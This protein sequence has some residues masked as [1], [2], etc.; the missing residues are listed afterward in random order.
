MITLK[1]FHIHL[2]SQGSTL[3]PIPALKQAGLLKVDYNEAMTARDVVTVLIACTAL[4]ESEA[5]EHVIRTVNLL[6]ADGCS[7]GETLQG[8]LGSGEPG[9]AA[10]HVCHSTPWAR[11]VFL[12]GNVLD[13]SHENS[14]PCA[15]RNEAVISG[16]LVSMLSMKLNQ[17]TKGGWKNE[18]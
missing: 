12:N 18:S 9:I 16:G 13:Y 4:S 2:T 15:I 14:K 17:D 8:L 10:I 1:S 11:I 3:N 5:I 6:D 7:F